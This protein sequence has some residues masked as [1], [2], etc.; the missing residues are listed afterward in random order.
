MNKL[1]GPLVGTHVSADK[2]RQPGLPAG[3]SRLGPGSSLTCN[4]TWKGQTFEAQKGLPI[5]TDLPGS[6]ANP[7]ARICR[8]TRIGESVRAR[9]TNL[10]DDRSESLGWYAGVYPLDD[11]TGLRH[12]DLSLL[13][14][15]LTG[16]HLFH[17]GKVHI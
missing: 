4:P 12:H 9:Q 14:Q 13:Q 16:A 2:E 1:H 11:V 15:A 8:R 17:Y 5:H 6:R 7:S 3:L 10:S